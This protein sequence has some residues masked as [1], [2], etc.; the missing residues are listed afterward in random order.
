MLGN[1]I[2]PRVIGESMD[3]HPVTVLLALIVWGMLWGVVGM[4]LAT[5]LTAVMK[6]FFERVEYTRPLGD[7]LAGRLDRLQ[8]DE[9]RQLTEDTQLQAD[10][11]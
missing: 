8:A 2:E 1:L 7:L 6:I 3:L 11:P 5:P 10:Q 9:T 4:I